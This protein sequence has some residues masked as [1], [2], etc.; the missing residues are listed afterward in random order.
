MRRSIKPGAIS[1]FLFSLFLSLDDNELGLLDH[2]SRLETFLLKYSN[3]L[4]VVGPFYF[5]FRL[6]GRRG[7]D[8]GETRRKEDVEIRDVFTGKEAAY[9]K[10][11]IRILK[12]VS[13]CF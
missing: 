7:V 1:P 3:E 5:N 11:N 6:G 4:L 2:D 12:R 10:K 13:A 9:K 8:R